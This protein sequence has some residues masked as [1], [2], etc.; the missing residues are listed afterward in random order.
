M[1]ESTP[2]EPA[3]PLAALT[4]AGLDALLRRAIRIT[5]VLGV[6]AALIVWKAS[7]WQNAAMLATG[8]AISALSILEWQRFVRFINAKLD[9]KQTPS[10]AAVAAVFFVVRLIIFAG[11]IYGS[12][13]WIRGSV[14]ALLCGLG[15]AALAMLWEAVK[16]LRN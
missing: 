11:V 6:L 4:D 14:V 7:S 2:S 5:L 3:H 10:G 13:K 1:N 15:L 9:Q 8:T 16:L 12:L